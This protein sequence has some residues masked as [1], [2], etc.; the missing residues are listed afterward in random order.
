MYGRDEGKGD[1]H[2]GHEGSGRDQVSTHW[3]KPVNP[4]D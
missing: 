3:P 4:T 2:V 1:R